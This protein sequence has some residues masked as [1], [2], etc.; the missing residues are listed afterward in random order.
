VTRECTCTPA[1]VTRYQKR[2]VDSLPGQVFIHAG[3]P[4]ELSEAVRA[5][6]EAAL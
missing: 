1:S 2:S 4:G 5:P 3:V 6:M